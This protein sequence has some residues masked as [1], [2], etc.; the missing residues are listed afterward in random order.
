MVDFRITFAS[1]ASTTPLGE[2]SYQKHP[3]YQ[4]ELGHL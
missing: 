3:P 2:T 1:S 4:G